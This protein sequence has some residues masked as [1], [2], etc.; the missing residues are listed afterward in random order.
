LESLLGEELPPAIAKETTRLAIEAA[1]ALG[2]CDSVSRW[3]RASHFGPAFEARA[4]D[5]VERC[6][7]AWPPVVKPR[8]E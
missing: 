3:A 8:L 1:F 7:F 4:A 2:H 6:S 5:W